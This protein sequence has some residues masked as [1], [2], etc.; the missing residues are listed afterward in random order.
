[1]VDLS[2][3][4]TDSLG[5]ISGLM[6]DLFTTGDTIE[7]NVQGSAGSKK[8]K[9]VNRG[10]TVDITD[11]EALIVPFSDDAGS[12]Q[13]FDMTLSDTSTTTVTYDETTNSVTIDSTSYSPG[14]SFV[15][16]GK[17]VV[18]YEL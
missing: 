8:S 9:F 10:S 6:D 13:T 4:D 5:L 14:D 3:L 18:V 2:S 12:G 15:L 16:D 17:K 7:I 11:S 1:M